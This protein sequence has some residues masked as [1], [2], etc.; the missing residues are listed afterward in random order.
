MNGLN[1][2]FYQIIEKLFL[3]QSYFKSLAHSAAQVILV[4]AICSMAVNYALT[5]TGLKENIIKLLKAVVFYAV[6]MAA[7][8]N[9]VSWL[10]VQ[11][12]AWAQNSTYD[13][14]TQNAVNALKTAAA[15]SS[16]QAAAT[17]RK[18]TFGNKATVNS[19]PDR[20][21]DLYFGD[22]LVERRKAT[23]KGKIITYT[24]VAPAAF[25]QLI[26]LTAGECIT[27]YEDAPPV[28]LGMGIE[29][30]DMGLF[31]KGLLCG[32][33]VIIVSVFALL[34]YLMA[35][36]EFI[37]VSSVGIILFPFSLWDGSKFLTEKFISA[38]VGFSIK[39]LFCTIC[40]FL[41]LY[42]FAVLARHYTSTPFTGLP[43]EIIFIIFSCLLFFYLCK[44]APAVAQSLMTGSPSLNAAGAIG[45]AMG[46]VGAVAGAA[47]LGMRAATGGAG[48]LAQ[49]GGAFAGAAGASKEMG[50][51]KL[52]QLGAGIGAF[53][54]SIGGSA[55]GAVK[56]KA[57]DLTRSLMS[58]PASAMAGLGSSIPGGGVRSGG[59]GA[60][61][62]NKNSASQR[63]LNERNE[64][65][66]RKTM[67]QV[68]G[69][70]FAEGK[71]AGR[72]F[73]ADQALGM[74]PNAASIPGQTQTA[75]SS[76]APP[77][78]PGPSAPAGAEPRAAL[79]QADGE[80]TYTKTSIL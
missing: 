23:E 70:Q 71:S 11:T 53:A 8:P 52:E 17:G 61:G 3:I 62:H 34:E 2:A 79:A 48:T 47:G 12:I 60:G 66:S 14:T 57:G 42:G 25:L 15:E 35:Y 9:I 5:G 37:F 26:L 24:T 77:P 1:S 13:K 22:V 75:S 76:E 44:S 43:D 74:I 40:I 59:G 73:A 41:A 20:D 31:L 67:T 50:G 18:G 32:F 80:E 63:M 56:D 30:P 7:Y 6:V 33:L 51:G 68:M 28:K 39:L 69:E 46:A 38:L 55:A 10:T 72:S 54:G 4:I 45:A 78:E 36:M 64:D 16:R 19:N 29:I 21:P 65:G 27:A 49:A 58:T